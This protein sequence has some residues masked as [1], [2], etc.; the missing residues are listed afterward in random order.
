VVRAGGE[1]RLKVSINFLAPLYS[2]FLSAKQLRGAGL[3][4]GPPDQVKLA[5]E[6]FAGE[7][8]LSD[9]F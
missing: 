3:L 5:G 4:Q 6:L 8:R 1:G 9:F 2:G 7:P